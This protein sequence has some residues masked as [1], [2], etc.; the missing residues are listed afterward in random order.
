MSTLPHMLSYSYLGCK[1]KA[2][3]IISD[4]AFRLR[5]LQTLLALSEQGILAANLW[6]R[7]VKQHV[8]VGQ[9]L[10]DRD[11]WPQFVPSGKQK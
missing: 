4:I 3:R 11:E 5:H 7:M 10:L 1:R 8:I 9:R 6:L 2:Q